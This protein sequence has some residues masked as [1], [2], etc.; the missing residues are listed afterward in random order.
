MKIILSRKGFDSFSGGVP[1]PIFPDGELLSLPIPDKSSTIRYE[2]IAGNRLAT[3]GELVE[4]LAGIPQIHS[5]HLDPDLAARSIPRA[6]GWRPIFGQGG[7]A[8]TH[9]KNQGVG[10]GDVFLFF[11]LFRSVERMGSRWRYVRA[12]QPMHILFGWLQAAQRINVSEWPVADQWGLYHPHLARKPRTGDVIYVAAKRL[13]LPQVGSVGVAGAGLFHSFSQD[14]R[15]TAPD[16][17]RHGL[18]LLPK[19]FHPANHASSLS[20]HGDAA[21]WKKTSAGTALSSVGRGQEF[22]LD[23]TDYPE[24]IN[25]L[26]KFF[27]T[28]GSR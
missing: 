15:L 28:T 2:E 26:R 27:V 6:K 4:Q 8:E 18:W 24:A 7:P 23:C 11:G 9:L 25:W 20:Y 22:V 17:G 16:S 1:S 5:A 19:W 13:V 21:R 12:S 3:V 10:P 14:L